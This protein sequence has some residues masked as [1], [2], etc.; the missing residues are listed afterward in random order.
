MKE[1]CHS[2]AWLRQS[3]VDRLRNNLA[4][5]PLARQLFIPGTNGFTVL[6]ECNRFSSPFSQSFLDQREASFGSFVSSADVEARFT[7]SL[8]FHH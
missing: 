6:L 7:A 1:G 2:R 4:H 8:A 5:I 3:L